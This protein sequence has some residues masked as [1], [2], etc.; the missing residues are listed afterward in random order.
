MKVK[1]KVE[2]LDRE[3]ECEV[4][5]DL[6][7]ALLEHNIP[8]YG[9]IAKLTNCKGH[10]LCGTCRIEVVDG[11]EGLSDQTFYEKMRI[12]AKDHTQ[13]LA[14]L[15]RCYQD[16]VIRTFHAPPPDLYEVEEA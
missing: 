2:N 10:A 7:S 14:C 6:R 4:G 15:T 9:P 3:I 8:L 1:V 16:A 13:R 5:Q 12:G 11:F